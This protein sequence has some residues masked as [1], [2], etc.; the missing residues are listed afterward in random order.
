MTMPP[1]HFMKK[2]LRTPHRVASPSRGRRRRRLTAAVLIGLVVLV[3]LATSAITWVGSE[4]ALRPAVHGYKWSL[5]TYPQLHAQP[6][7]F[8]SSTHVTIV[9]RFFPGSS[10]ATIVLSHGF[11]DTQEGMDPWAALLHDGGFSVLTYN[12]RERPGSGGEY[13][14][15]GALEQDDLVSA[16]EYLRTRH[17]VDPTRIGGLGVSLGGA[18]TILAA[19]RDTHLRAIVD[20]CGFSDAANVIDT[21]FTA[22]IHL[23]AFP[24]AT[25][26]VLLSELRAGVNIDEVQ[27][28]RVIS[29]ISARPILI[30]HGLADKLVPVDNSLR[31]YAAARQPKQLW[32]VPGAGHGQSRVVA[33]AAYNQRVVAFFRRALKT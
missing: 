13:S 32:L 16:V 27:P 12:M 2:L 22:F 6:V 8:K 7:S 3:L 30:I 5:A 21:S 33:G 24:F 10:K 26:T 23:P 20:D 9:G 1:P 14:T 15:L 19:A 18:V 25:L 29:L 31:N 28:A 17:D 11:G 4:T